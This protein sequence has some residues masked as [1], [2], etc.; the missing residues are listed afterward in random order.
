MR[1]FL[2]DFLSFRE[3]VAQMSRREDEFKLLDIVLDDINISGFPC[4]I[5]AR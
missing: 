1:I 2:R 3:L 4:D 5:Y